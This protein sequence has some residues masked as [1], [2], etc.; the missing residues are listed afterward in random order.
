MLA[1]KKAFFETI[2]DSKDL[3]ENL[4]ELADFLQENTGATG[5][6]IGKLVH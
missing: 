3:N 6:Y 4:Q 5:V 2:E 1:R